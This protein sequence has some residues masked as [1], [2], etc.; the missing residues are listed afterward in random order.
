MAW[1]LLAAT[2]WGGEPAGGDAGKTMSDH[3][4]GLDPAVNDGVLPASFESLP[5][6]WIPKVDP[7][8]KLSGDLSA[9]AWK[10]AASVALVDIVTNVD[11]REKTEAFVFC[12]ER[13]LY[14]GFRCHESALDQL[15]VARGNVCQHDEVEIFLEPRKDTIRRPYHQIFVDAAGTKDFRRHHVYAKDGNRDEFVEE[16]KPEIE[17][18]AGRGENCWTVEVK[19]PFDQLRLSN[20]ALAKTTLWRMNLYRA[21]PSK[22][23]VPASYSG[24]SPTGAAKFH[25]PAKFGFALPEVFASK[26]LLDKVRRASSPRGDDMTEVAAALPEIKKKIVELGAESYEDRCAASQRLMDMSGISR[27]VAEAL[28]KEL[29]EAVGH[30]SDAEVVLRAKSILV[31]TKEDDPSPEDAKR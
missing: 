5:L 27:A 12:T 7:P 28:K 20:A 16:W 30:S 10:K 25:V 23:N 15:E 24:W 6:M 18:A 14:F 3:R 13:A 4:S 2:C 19:V 1:M 8:D 9:P 22:G 31:D 11:P 26:E 21:R 17:V 29:L